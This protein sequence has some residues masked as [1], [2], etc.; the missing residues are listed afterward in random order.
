[1]QLFTEPVM[2]QPSIT[3]FR[4]GTDSRIYRWLGCHYMGDGA[5]VFRVWAPNARAVSLVGDFNGW[6]CKASPM[7]V[8]EGGI[9]EIT[10]QGL[11]EY[12]VYKYAVVPQDGSLVMKGDPCGFHF[13]T[14]PSNA[15][16]IY[17]I[18]GYH[19]GDGAW[20]E[21]KAGSSLYDRPVNIYEVHAGSWRRYPDGAPFSYNKLADE[22]IPYVQEMGYT[23]IE[24]LPVMEH[25][26]DG[27]WGY[28]VTGYFAPTSRYG[29][30]RIS[31]DLLTAAIRLVS[32]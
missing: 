4:Q 15:S 10:V 1:M 20:L 11:E 31:W 8:G 12:A 32:G 27:S 5:Y 17:N 24:L 9:W 19:W 3:R 22:L 18:N 2:E 16:K 13:E 26:F 25:P 28:Q 29:E 7:A 6:D 23:H 21:K 14:R 30:R